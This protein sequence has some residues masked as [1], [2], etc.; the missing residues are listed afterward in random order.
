MKEDKCKF[1]NICELAQNNFTCLHSGG[2]VYCGKYRELYKESKK[3][4]K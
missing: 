3:G 2:G 4:D 1:F